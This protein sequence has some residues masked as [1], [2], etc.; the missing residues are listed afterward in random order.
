LELYGPFSSDE[1]S[2]YISHGAALSGTHQD[3]AAQL[4]QNILSAEKSSSMF[5]HDQE[6]QIMINKRGSHPVG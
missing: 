3:L 4:D 6:P 2:G 1:E 5:D